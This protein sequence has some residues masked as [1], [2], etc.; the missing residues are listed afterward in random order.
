M[1]GEVNGVGFGI[2]H[3]DEFFGYGRDLGRVSMRF[4]GLQIIFCSGV[5]L[6]R[7]LLI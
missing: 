2:F 7:R 1:V 4:Q 5:S 6:I 3:G